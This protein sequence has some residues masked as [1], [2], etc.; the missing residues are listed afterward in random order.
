MFSW[1]FEQYERVGAL[2]ERTLAQA[3]SS[4]AAGL[5]QPKR[6]VAVQR[7]RSVLQR[8]ADR[9]ERC[10]RDQRWPHSEVDGRG[11]DLSALSRPPRLDTAG[12][13]LACPG[14]GE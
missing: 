1:L 5:C 13:E 12:A 9:R 14:G 4:C 10:A 6:T 8:R 7:R 3:R 2:H 11:W